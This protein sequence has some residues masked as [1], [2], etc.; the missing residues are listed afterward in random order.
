MD[1]VMI[2]PGSTGD[3]TTGMW[4][5]IISSDTKK[6]IINGVGDILLHCF[7]LFL[8]LTILFWVIISKTEKKAVNDQ[9]LNG[10]DNLN[11]KIN[12]VPPALKSFLT[13]MYS[14][15]NGYM[16][17]NN[18][19]VLKLNITILLM[20]FILLIV[21][22]TWTN[23]SGVA[24]WPRIILENVVILIGVGIVEFLFFKFVASKYVPVMPTFLIDEVQS[25]LSEHK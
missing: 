3:V 15:P 7:L 4:D 13:N 12:N 10:I 1:D 11:S 5:N 23:S 9:I 22:A 17:N 8:F 14:K 21:V 24:N 20:W 19:L 25:V 18:S 6:K 16:E 2:S